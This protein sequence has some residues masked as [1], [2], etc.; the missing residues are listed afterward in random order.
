KEMIQ[1]LFHFAADPE[2]RLRF[3]FIE[4]YDMEVARFL[5]QGADIWLNTPRRP[6]EACGTSGMKAALNGAVNCSILDGWWDECYNGANGWAIG[7][8]YTYLDHE[9]QDRVESSALY[10]LLERDVVAR[11]YDRPEGPIPR[12]WIERMKSSIES[13]G[14]FVT[15]DRMLRD[16]VENLYEPASR[17]SKVMNMEDHKR[18]RDLA[19]WKARVRENWDG[20]EFLEVHGEETTADVGEPRMVDALLRV[21]HLTTDDITV[22]LCHGRVGANGEILEPTIIEMKAGECD[23]QGLCSYQGSFATEAPG[24]YGLAVRAVPAHRDLSSPMDMGLLV[25][26]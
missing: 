15:A 12:R 23:D 3:A 24:L 20:V 2:V 18:A 11:F 1:K 19:A 6:L 25:W 4:D 21:G 10:D 13:L 22:Q 9:H 26:A 16:Y 17:Q 8:V 14:P 7:T 5:C